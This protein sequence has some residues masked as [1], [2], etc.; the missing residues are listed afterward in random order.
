LWNLL[1]SEGD[2]KVYELLYNIR[3]NKTNNILD[4]YE[5]KYNINNE[6]LSEKEK[7]NITKDAIHDLDQNLQVIEGPFFN[8]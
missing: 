3:I 1:K 4:S 5:T 7:E 8:I 6:A 2:I